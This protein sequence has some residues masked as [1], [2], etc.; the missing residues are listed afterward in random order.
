MYDQAAG[1]RALAAKNKQV[2]VEQKSRIIAVA[3]GKGGV[4]KTSFSINVA[5]ALQDLDCRVLIIDADLGTANV[6]VA[7]GIKPDKNLGDIIAERA[8]FQ[9][10][11]TEGP[12]GIDILAGTTADNSIFGLNQQQVAHLLSSASHIEKNYDIIM[13]DVGAGASNNVINFVLAADETFLITTPEPSSIMDVYSLVKILSNYRKK[14]NLSL[15]V[16][17]IESEKEGRQVSGRIQRVIQEYIDITINLI[18]VIPFDRQFSQ[19]LKK[20]QAFI[21]NY[22]NSKASYAF[23]DIAAKILDRKNVVPARGLKGFLYRVAGV[24]NRE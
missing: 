7:L 17:Q 9:E 16:N 18:G 6:D 15:L 12:A 24:L 1:L 11:I 22:P 14:L 20:Q 4:G 21:D 3:S 10:A 8:T 23:R 2:T 19:A 5:I 13:L